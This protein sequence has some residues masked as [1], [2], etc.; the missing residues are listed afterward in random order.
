M[1]GEGGREVGREGGREEGREGG[2][3]RGE[4]GKRK[5]GGRERGREEGEGGREGG[6]EGGGG[7][8]RRRNETVEKGAQLT[9]VLW[10]LSAREIWRN[11]FLWRAVC[12]E[13][14]LADE[15]QRR[16]TTFANT[17]IDTLKTERQGL[18]TGR[19]S[20]RIRGGRGTCDPQ[21]F[22]MG[23][24]PPPPPPNN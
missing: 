21:Y 7:G 11:I 19:H 5:E 17:T 15:A 1:R 4:V 12:F 3:G 13:Q 16:L 2:K 10:L 22:R 23:D 6:R 20:G 8:G 9:S 14:G 18:N 24:L